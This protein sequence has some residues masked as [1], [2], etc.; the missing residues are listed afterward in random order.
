MTDKNILV[1]GGF[2]FIGST[3]VEQLLAEPGNRVHV[4]DNL[5]TSPIDVTAFLEVVGNPPNLSY[6]ICSIA[7]YCTREGDKGKAFREIYHLASPVG[8][9]G[10]L[11]YAGKM[12]EMICGDAYHVINLGLKH[13]AKVL[14]ISTSEVY[15]GGRDGYCS[16]DYSKIIPAKVTVRLE[17]AVAKLAAEISL[18]NTTRVTPLRACIIRP[19]N[20]AGPRQSPKGGF[21]LP[22]FIGQALRNEP[23]TVYSD[24]SMVRAFTHVQDI[25]QGLILTMERGTNGEAYNLGNPANKV[26][27]LELAQRVVKIAESQSRIDHVDPKT[28]FGPL[29]EEANDKYPDAK[30]ST[31]ELGW[32]PRSDVD[33]VIRDTLHYIRDGRK[34]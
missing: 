15:G 4:V 14:D 30:R 18:V 16:E 17:Y 20:V 1:T 22:R 9:V 34:A 32:Q 27:I 21:V 8:P 12:T 2:G 23:L 19:F 3:L 29:F 24:G 5:S 13:D 7:E 26:T 6:D 11:A 33:Q 31:E 25:V 10:V 28:L